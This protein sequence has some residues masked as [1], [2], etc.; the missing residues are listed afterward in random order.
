MDVTIDE[1]IKI[2]QELG[3]KLRSS[4]SIDFALHA[5]KGRSL[6][7]RIGLLWRAILIDHPFS[8]VNKRT[9]LNVTFLILKRNRIK[10]D[11]KAKERIT[12]ELLKVTKKNINS[13][14]KIERG[15]RYA[16]EGN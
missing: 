8:D 13:I 7:W 14:K 10:L 16:V 4:S 5:G 12:K 2:N 11:E 1:I 6:Y 15:L 3:G 9:T